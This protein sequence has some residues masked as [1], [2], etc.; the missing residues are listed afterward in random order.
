M[1]HWLMNFRKRQSGGFGFAPSGASVQ[2][3]EAIL[4]N[5]LRAWV[6]SFSLGKNGSVRR[7]LRRYTIDKLQ[8]FGRLESEQSVRP[9]FQH[10]KLGCEFHE[11]YIGIL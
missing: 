5:A 1:L 11:G 10:A 3:K 9:T 7:I 2:R 4:T 8:H 6:E